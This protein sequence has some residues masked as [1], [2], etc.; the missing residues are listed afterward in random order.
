MAFTLDIPPAFKAQK[1]KVKIRDRE[2]NEPPHITVIRGTQSWRYGLR[3]GDFLDVQPDPRDVPS[4]LLEFIRSAQ[5]ELVDAW[6]GMYPENPVRS[7][8][9]DDAP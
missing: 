6:D 1:W 3:E 5:A 8:E 7:V 4:D 9:N 2:R